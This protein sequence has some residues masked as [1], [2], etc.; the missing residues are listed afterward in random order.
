MD[1]QWSS[2]RNNCATMNVARYDNGDVIF[3]NKRARRDSV[4]SHFRSARRRVVVS[5]GG[6]VH[7]RA[8]R[9]RISV[10]I[11]PRATQ[12]KLPSR[13]MLI[14]ARV[15]IES[16]R[17]RARRFSCD[18]FN[19]FTTPSDDHFLSIFPS[20]VEKRRSATRLRNLFALFSYLIRRK[21]DVWR[22]NKRQPILIDRCLHEQSTRMAI[23]AGWYPASLSLFG[24]KRVNM[25]TLLRKLGHASSRTVVRVSCVAILAPLKRVWN[26]VS[27]LLHRVACKNVVSRWL[28]ITALWYYTSGWAE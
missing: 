3:V 10:A 19:I 18:Y 28:N 6:R 13:W 12:R 24:V 5:F 4:S 14:I 15:A 9:M 21:V 27:P 7:C 20:T 1:R 16:L 17:L 25:D 22:D 26:A 2:S 11:A 23:I 8:I